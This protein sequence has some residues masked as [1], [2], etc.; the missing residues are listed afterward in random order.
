MGLD[1]DHRAEEED[2]FARRPALRV[3]ICD[4]IAIAALT[5]EEV[6]L[7]PDDAACGI[8]Q[9]RPTCEA[10]RPSRGPFDRLGI[11][12][13]LG[14]CT[15]RGHYGVE[16]SYEASSPRRVA[17]LCTVRPQRLTASGVRGR[18]TCCAQ[19]Q[20]AHQGGGS[21]ARADHAASMNCREQV[22]Q[23]HERAAG[24]GPWNQRP[25]RIARLRRRVGVVGGGGRGVDRVRRLLDGVAAPGGG[26][27]FD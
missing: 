8:D 4:L 6:A 20:H 10:D 16:W 14:A 19:S 7:M 21:K 5:G 9:R 18:A 13:D 3:G 1:R 22:H 25:D 24:G 27:P 11:G 2:R 12:S 26:G 15:L 17:W 23:L